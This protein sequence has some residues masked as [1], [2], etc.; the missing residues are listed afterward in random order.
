LPRIFRDATGMPYPDPQFDDGQVFSADEMW[1]LRELSGGD[2]LHYQLTR[3]LLD[4]SRRYRSMARR[5]RLFE[6]LEG[7]FRRSFYEDAEDATAFARARQ[8][9]R[10]AAARGERASLPVL[11]ELIEMLEVGDDATPGRDA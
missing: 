10:D 9:L 4:V 7:A 1:L 2:E 6:D 5:A 11:N 3:E 8:G